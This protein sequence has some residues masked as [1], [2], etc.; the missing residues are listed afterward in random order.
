MDFKAE[1]PLCA[2]YC[3]YTYMFYQSDY[4]RALRA[5]DYHYYLNYTSVFQHCVGGDYVAFI[6]TAT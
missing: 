4:L 1:L 2:R 5:K 3:K 6:S